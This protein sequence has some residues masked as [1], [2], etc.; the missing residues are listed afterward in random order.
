[1]MPEKPTRRTLQSLLDNVEN[2]HK[3]DIFTFSGGYLNESKLYKLP[4]EMTSAAW[5]SAKKS[6]IPVATSKLPI[7]S[8]GRNA[9]DHKM[10]ETLKMFSL[11]SSGAVA[12]VSEKPNRA[13][14]KGPLHVLRKPSAVSSQGS[15]SARDD[16]I[17]VE[18]M[19]NAETMVN[20]GKASKCVTW[21]QYD[22]RGSSQDSSNKGAAAFSQAV[23]KD[24]NL[25]NIK[26]KFLPSHLNAVTKKD[27][28]RKLMSFEHTVL[29]KYDT[30]EQNVM[31]GAKA[32]DHLE[33]KLRDVSKWFNE[34]E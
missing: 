27:Q 33:T 5:P 6:A 8:V 25:G 1:M 7:P 31:S 28:Y 23:L 20:A 11:G 30:M 29:Q 3:K 2:V 10:T 24:K 9:K 16:G 21:D 34:M 22:L 17:L 14:T 18:N 12:P 26:H 15:Y 4:R 19:G 13:G 32:V